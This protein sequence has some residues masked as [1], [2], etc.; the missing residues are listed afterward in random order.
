LDFV[1]VEGL[2]KIFTD[3]GVKVSTARI[4]KRKFGIKRSK[5]FGFVDCVNEEEQKKALALD[6]TEVEARAI[7][8]KV[9]SLC[10]LGLLKG[11]Y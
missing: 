2:N 10:S 8:V 1:P 7:A 4:V 11:F 3:G 5:G 6:G 9:S